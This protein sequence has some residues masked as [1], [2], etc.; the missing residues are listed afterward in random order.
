MSDTQSNQKASGSAPNDT[1]AGAGPSAG[2]SA[3][4]DTAASQPT[5]KAPT[6]YRF[7]KDHWGSYSNFHYSH[8][9]KHDPDDFEEGDRILEAYIE[10]ERIEHGDLAY[11][12]RKVLNRP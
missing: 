11:A 9:L 5:Y 10:A 8:G 6:K 2:K 1:R 3:P 12:D 4:A 7:A